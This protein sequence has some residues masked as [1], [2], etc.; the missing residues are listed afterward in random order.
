M[1]PAVS[2]AATWYALSNWIGINATPHATIYLDS[3]L[4]QSPNA[5]GHVLVRYPIPLKDGTRP[6][7]FG[8]NWPKGLFVQGL[9][10]SGPGN[11]RQKL[12]TLLSQ[13][14][15]PL[16]AEQ[17]YFNTIAFFDHVYE[18]QDLSRLERPAK[19]PA[20]E[21]SGTVPTSDRSPQSRSITLW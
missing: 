17:K 4:T 7:L 18:S 2:D 1:G 3:L 6:D 5:L 8:V 11:A 21:H 12:L 9:S 14:R 16:G 19:A 20:S 10:P 13:H 15:V